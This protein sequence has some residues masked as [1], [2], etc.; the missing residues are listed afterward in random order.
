MVPE[1]C[2]VTLGPLVK[3]EPWELV[4]LL[5]LVDPVG[6]LAY[7][8]LGEYLGLMDLRDLKDRWA[9]WGR[10]DLKDL[11][12][13]LEMLEDPDLL[14]CKDYEEHQ[15]ELVNLGFRVR[16]ER[17]ENQGRMVRMENLDL[18]E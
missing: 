11:R 2:L 3:E 17:L 14:D 18:S 13:R 4:V 9:I 8:V 1:V 15:V 12:G 7:L 5:D 16:M 10:V 6:S